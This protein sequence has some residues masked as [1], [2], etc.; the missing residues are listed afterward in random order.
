MYVIVLPF[1]VQSRIWGEYLLENNR[2]VGYKPLADYP[3]PLFAKQIMYGDKEIYGERKVELM[4]R[5]YSAKVD[6]INECSEM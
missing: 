5:Y 6:I 2:K 3:N 1:L 4:K